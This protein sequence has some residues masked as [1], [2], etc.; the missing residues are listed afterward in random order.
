MKT[1]KI[2]SEYI[3]LGQML[4]LAGVVTSGVE[5]KML[6]LD[7][8]VRVNGLIENRRGRKLVKDDIINVESEDFIIQ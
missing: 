6:I 8:M 1:I 3:K 2:D 7:D 4:K 5:A